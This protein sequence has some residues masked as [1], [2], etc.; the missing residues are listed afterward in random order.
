MEN[1]AQQHDVIQ[2]V[3]TSKEEGSGNIPVFPLSV[4]LQSLLVFAWSLPDIDSTRQMYIP[5]LFGLPSV[6]YGAT[7]Q[8]K[9]NMASVL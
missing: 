2:I 4:S 8:F 7:S 3:N 9:T 1:K 6:R 5:L